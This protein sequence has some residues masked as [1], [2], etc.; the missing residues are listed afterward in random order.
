MKILLSSYVFSPS[1]GGIETVSALLAPE[2]VRAGHDVI[3]VTTTKQDD[4]KSWPFEVHR[5][6]TPAKFIEL[7]RWCDVF[8]QNNISLNLAWPLLFVP[9]PW[10]I[11]HSTWIDRLSLNGNLRSQ[12]KRSLLKYGTNITISR[13]VADDIS[14]TST[15]AG[16]PY[17]DRVFQQIPGISRD[18]ELVYLGRLV[19]DKGVDL[20]IQSLVD[21]RKL[22]LSPR[23]TIIG[24][25]P[26]ESGLRLMA[27]NLGVEAQITFTGSKAPFE[28]ARLLNTHLVMVVPSL[29][30]EPFGIVVLEGLGSGCAV[31]AAK[32]GGLPEVLG[33]CGL[34]FEMG[35]RK[36]LTQALHIMLTQPEM[37]QKF[38]E[39]AE[40]HLNQFKAATVASRYLQVF[41]RAI[42]KAQS[43]C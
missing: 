25:G 38:L 42:H 39:H 6:P 27:A 8:Y 34:L 12:L 5:N 41:E 26:A 22:G 14:V 20:L 18:H 35:N 40:Q 19:S 30:P 33:P 21:L 2:F 15:I 24:S 37:R 31:V 28:I 3:L 29:W 1:V 10:V 32:A 16:N 23:L 4:G 36:A 43:S 17:S 7:M 11:S 13:V 9:R